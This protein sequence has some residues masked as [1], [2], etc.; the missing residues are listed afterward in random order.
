[1]HKTRLFHRDI[2]PYNIYYSPDKKGYVLG[3][4]GNAINLTGVPNGI[5]TNLA[6]VPYYLPFYLKHVG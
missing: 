3:G 1:M 6:A 2:R 5:G 4:F